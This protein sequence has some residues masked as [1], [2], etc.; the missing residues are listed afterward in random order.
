MGYTIPPNYDSMIA[1]LC[2]W[3]STRLEAIKRMRRAIS[4]Y[5]ILGIKTTLPLHYAIMNNPQFVEGNTHTHFLQEEHILNTLERYRRDEETRMQ[6]LAGSFGQG[7]KVA[8]I[9]AA[10]NMYLQQKND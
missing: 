3:D 6:T 10:V 5:I 9:S 1:K 2:A 8:A 7:K 4:E